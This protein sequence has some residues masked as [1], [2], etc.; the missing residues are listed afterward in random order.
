LPI[1]L[2]WRQLI[3]RVDLFIGLLPAPRIIRLLIGFGHRRRER[4]N[5][6][7]GSA[8][9]MDFPLYMLFFTLRGKK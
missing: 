4:L 8:A 6:L 9:I 1:R 7:L 2:A 3:R 5:L